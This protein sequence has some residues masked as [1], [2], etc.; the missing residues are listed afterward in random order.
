VVLIVAVRLRLHF[1]SPEVAYACQR[2]PPVRSRR[3]SPDRVG[4]GPKPNAPRTIYS[5]VWTGGRQ[6]FLGRLA[7]QMYHV[8]INQPQWW[9]WVAR[10]TARNRK[11]RG[12]HGSCVL[13]ARPSPRHCASEG[14][15]LQSGGA[16]PSP[17][18]GRASNQGAPRPAPVEEQPHH[19][20][21]GSGGA[22]LGSAD[23]LEDPPLGGIGPSSGRPPRRP[24]R[25]GL[26]DS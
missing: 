14:P 20:D 18:R 24:E 15:S 6:G 11:A 5:A 17:V 1:D 12:V 19:A 26:S 23:V 13:Q 25:D 2:Y 9:V 16:A 8:C 3:T 4:R 7:S 22:P 10:G 21:D